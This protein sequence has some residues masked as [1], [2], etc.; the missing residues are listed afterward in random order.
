MRSSIAPLSRPPAD[1][2]MPYRPPINAQP[3]PPPTPDRFGSLRARFH[4]L[5]PARRLM[6]TGL[7]TLAIV[8][9]IMTLIY[10]FLPEA[11][12]TILTPSGKTSDGVAVSSGPLSGQFATTGDARNASLFFDLHQYGDDLAGKFISVTC[13]QGQPT[14]V[15]GIVTGQMLDQDA[16]SLTLAA[17]DEPHATTI[18]YT[19]TLDTAGF[20]LTWRDDQG[21]AQVR[22]WLPTSLNAFGADGGNVC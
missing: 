16:V 4:A 12:E 20:D 6:L 22:H 7:A 14:T 18:I 2:P 17:P 19:L 8:V 11:S 21:H 9:L 5:S 1:R 13:D 3:E 15:E 10:A